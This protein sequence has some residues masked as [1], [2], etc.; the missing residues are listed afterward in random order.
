MYNSFEVLNKL[1]FVRTGGSN[2]ELEA[3]KIIQAECDKRRR[4]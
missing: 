3:A 2:E 1:Y 4:I